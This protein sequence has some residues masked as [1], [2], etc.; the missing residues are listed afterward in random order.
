M[1]ASRV[2]KDGDGL[3]GAGSMRRSGS[4]PISQRTFTSS[5]WP[6][7]ISS[8]SPWRSGKSSRLQEG[9]GGLFTVTSTRVTPPLPASR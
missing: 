6:G 1:A 3:Y 4:M 8:V 9:G 7:T 5:T 2:G